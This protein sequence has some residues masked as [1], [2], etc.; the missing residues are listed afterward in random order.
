MGFEGVKRKGNEHYAS[1][2]RAW[3]RVVDMQFMENIWDQSQ[4]LVSE[5]RWHDIIMVR[6][7]S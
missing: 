5:W 6:L 1:L 3:G 7:L 4:D 2:G